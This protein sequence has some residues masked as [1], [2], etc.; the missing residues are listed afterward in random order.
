MLLRLRAGGALE[1]AVYGAPLAKGAPAVVYHHGWP[2][3]RHEAA[4]LHPHALELG[5]SLVAINRPG[6]GRSTL[7]A[8]GFNFQT[9]ADDV[10]QLLE[11]HGLRRVAFMGTSGGGP[12]ACACACLLPERAAAV[13]LM[14]GMTQTREA[15]GVLRGLSLSNRLMYHAIN[16]APGAMGLTM[17][18]GTAG[19]RLAGSVGLGPVAA[20]ARKAAASAAR[21]DGWSGAGGSGGAWRGAGGSGGGEGGG[22]GASGRGGGAGGGAGAAVRGEADASAEAPAAAAMAPA[23]APAAAAAVKEGGGAGGRGAARSGWGLGLSAA[24]T[25][26]VLAAAGFSAVD[27]AA[28]ARVMR[29]RPEVAALM[30]GGSSEVAAQGLEGLWRDM[31]LTSEPWGLP[32]GSITAPTFIW[33]GDCDQNVTVAMAR[34]L[35]AAIPGAAGRLRIVPGAGHISLGLDHGAQALAEVAEVL[36]AQGD[37]AG[38]LE[39]Q[40]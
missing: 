25:W 20:A 2:S 27:R 11:H 1:Y 19:L 29:E 34:H 28:V 32:L 6:V 18:A 15:P 31:R 39:G 23:A 10:R 4:F 13:C 21:A 30:A 5:L 16:Y 12:Y 36:R 22:G 38:K 9:V 3:S 26:L 40:A 33:Q 37:V 17:G 35:A 8:R 14:A 7:D 24:A